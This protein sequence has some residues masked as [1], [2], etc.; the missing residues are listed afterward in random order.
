MPDEI[1]EHKHPLRL[2]DLQPKYPQYEETFDV[3]NVIGVAKKSLGFTDSIDDR[4]IYHPSH[5]HPLAA[6]LEPLLS[7]CNACGKKHEGTFYICTTCFGLFI[8]SDCAFLPEEFMIQNA[9]NDIFSHRHPLILS[10]S[11]PLEDQ[12]TRFH[13]RCRVCNST[14]YGANTWIFKCEKCRYYVHIHCATSKDPGRRLAIKNFED[15]DY[16]DLLHLPFADEGCSLQK[17]MFSKLVEHGTSEAD[18]QGNVKHNLHPHP[19]ILVRT[20]CNDITSTSTSTKTTVISC[21]NP[22]KKV[23]LLCNACVRPVTSVPFYKCVND[24]CNFVLH[25]WCS[26]LPSQVEK[27]PGHPEHTL[28]LHSNAL[29]KFLYVF[30]CAWFLVVLET[31][32]S[33]DRTSRAFLFQA[34]TVS[35]PSLLPGIS[36]NGYENIN[37]LAQQHTSIQTLTKAKPHLIVPHFPS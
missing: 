14:E 19:L 15:S 36:Q 20:E 25:E 28:I 21:H 29:K 11:F 8:H 32:Q 13:P 3:V 7:K 33:E 18:D 22:M 34:S 1:R 27:Y 6:T 23:Q 31:S 17:H 30:Q 35:D 16:P 2:I 24:D 5:R 4:L 37:Q 26:Q 12:I 9:T 10:Y